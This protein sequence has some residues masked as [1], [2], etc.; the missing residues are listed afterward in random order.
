MHLITM[1][2]TSLILA[3][4]VATVYT[5]W[6][7]NSCPVDRS[8]RPLV[9]PMICSMAWFL[10]STDTAVAHFRGTHGSVDGTTVIVLI[11]VTLISIISFTKA[12]VKERRHS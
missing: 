3:S 12:Y 5:V 11:V 9:F 8:H 7:Y 4:L 10:V 6:A 1:A 2:Y